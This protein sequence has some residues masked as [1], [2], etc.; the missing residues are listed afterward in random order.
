M[1]G[2]WTLHQVPT[3][4]RYAAR[5][6]GVC[7]TKRNNRAGH[8][9]GNLTILLFLLLAAC[10]HS[11]HST[12]ASSSGGNSSMPALPLAWNLANR[13]PNVDPSP[14]HLAHSHTRTPSH[15]HTRRE[16]LPRLPALTYRR[17]LLH[18]IASRR[19]AVQ[20]CQG[21][22]ISPLET[23]PFLLGA[24]SSAASQLNHGCSGASGAN[25]RARADK[26]ETNTAIR[27]TGPI[28]PSFCPPCQLRHITTPLSFSWL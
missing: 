20:P 23:F 26:A 14:S 24:S 18:R 8:D 4:L 10:C 12:Q 22:G 27:S 16:A 5:S 6:Q 28:S 25:S 2:G 7:S 3:Y 9:A 15:I 17:P 13:S 11:T 21:R 19:A 1:E